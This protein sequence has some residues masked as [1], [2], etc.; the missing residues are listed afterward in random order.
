[1]NPN[2]NPR[3]QPF[4]HLRTVSDLSSVKLNS[5]HQITV[6]LPVR[7]ALELTAGDSMVFKIKNKLVSLHRH[8]PLDRAYTQALE[9]N[10]QEWSSSAD[11][12]AFKDL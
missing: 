8:T 12:E 10:L 6:P 3:C 1:M 2:G 5:K 11:D 9:S 4:E 7:Q